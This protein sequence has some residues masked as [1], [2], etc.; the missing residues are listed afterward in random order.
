M[1][2]SV[3]A[4]LALL[5]FAVAIV[6][7]LMAG[8][9]AVT[10]LSRAMICMFMAAMLG[11]LVAWMAKMVLRDTLQ[12]RKVKLDQ[13]HVNALEVIE[14]ERRAAEAAQA[15]HSGEIP[16]AEAAPEEASGPRLAKAS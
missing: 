11:Q 7:G 16:L 6:A 14:N 1:I 4:Q 8:N 15:Q 9:G 3:G 5:A 2:G 12:A 10:I 13:A